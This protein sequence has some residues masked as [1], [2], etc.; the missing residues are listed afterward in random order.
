MFRK[1]SG[2]YIIPV[3]IAIIA[4]YFAYFILLRDNFFNTS[5]SSII[6]QSNHFAVRMH[7]IILGLLP[8]YIGA[9]IFGSGILS[10]FL[11][12]FVQKLLNHNKKHKPF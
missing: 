4:I 6:A 7:L 5:I 12:A 10:L 1:I 8:I 2:I 11:N 9:I 3:I